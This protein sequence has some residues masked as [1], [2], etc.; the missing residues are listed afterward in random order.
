[1]HQA[2][3]LAEPE[4]FEPIG[5]G[6]A[7]AVLA[8]GDAQKRAAARQKIEGSNA[9][10]LEAGGAGGIRTLDTPLERITV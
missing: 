7:A 10:S 4:G 8:R 3:R 9:S 5:R 6:F 1:M 2:L